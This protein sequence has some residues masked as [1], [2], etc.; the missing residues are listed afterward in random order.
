[1][2][3]TPFWLLSLWLLLFSG[4]AI[5]ELIRSLERT[6]RELSN[7]LINI[8]QKDFL[9]TYSKNNSNSDELNKAFMLI[10]Q[11]FQQ[12][13][14]EKESNYHFLQTV[15]EHSGVPLMVYD[16]ET[17]KITLMN[18][19]AK[20]LF[21]RPHLTNL[22][23]IEQL[24]KHLFQLILKLQSG[25]KE[26]IKTVIENELLHLS[27]LA[28]EI[29]LDD[30]L[31]KLISFQNIKA[32]L[33]EQEIQSWQK[34]IRVLTHEIKNSA[35]PISTLTEVIN[36]MIVDERGELKDLSQLQQEDLDDL[37]IGIRTV[38]KRSAGLVNFVNAYGELAKIPQPKFQRVHV[39]E[40]VERTEA[41]LGPDLKRAGVKLTKAVD[42]A[43]QIEADMDMVEQILINLIKNAKEALVNTEQPCIELT[44][45]IK[46]HRTVIVVKDNG[47]GIE[48]EAMDQIFVPFYT[49]KKQGSGIGLSLSRQYMRAQKGNLTVTSSPEAGTSFF[50]IF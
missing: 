39:L 9:G 5:Y 28:R 7:F 25:Q 8:K 26:L 13:R 42:P 2:T 46:N 12:L 44:T 43:L 20:E 27:V 24:D 33:D 41:L 19:A 48:A 10:T 30:R 23:S 16:E 36:Q 18:K 1:M 45:F 38:Q 17:L 29:K 21:K 32:E 34:L 40:L 31:H 11:E 4:I 6:K 49:T 35:I 37:K 22:K 47:P 14:K 3:E 50:M 15:V